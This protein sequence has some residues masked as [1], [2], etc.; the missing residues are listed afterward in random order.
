[1]TTK[2]FLLSMS[3]AIGSTV[4]TTANPHNSSIITNQDSRRKLEELS[5]VYGPFAGH[6]IVF[7]R[8]FETNV[9]F[10]VCS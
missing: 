1:M 4:I 2:L 10:R 8:C 6:S 9:I 7:D 5:P 3:A